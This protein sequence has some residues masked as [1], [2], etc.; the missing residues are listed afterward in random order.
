MKIKLSKRGVLFLVN[1]VFFA[2]TVT[3]Y[4]LCLY[5]LG[6]FN[7][8][9]K[10]DDKGVLREILFILFRYM[11]AQCIFTFF[12]FVVYYLSIM[13]GTLNKKYYD[14]MKEKIEE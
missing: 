1:G 8:N 12:S 4:I 11:L 7:Y 9:P 3:V 5:G 10:I 6:Y 14:K 2:V 13:A